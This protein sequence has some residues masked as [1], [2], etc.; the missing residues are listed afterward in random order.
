MKLRR[1]EV[2]LLAVCAL[3]PVLVLVAVWVFNGSIRKS[4]PI[5]ASS[6]AS[7]WK[8][9]VGSFSSA[10]EGERKAIKTIVAAM[11]DQLVK[12]PET[13]YA[14]DYHFVVNGTQLKGSVGYCPMVRQ[15]SCSLS[16]TPKH[17]T[18]RDV[19]PG[20]LRELAN[21]SESISGL[22]AR[23]YQKDES[24]RID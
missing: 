23:R 1:K 17:T 6:C 14:A 2:G 19:R 24:V 15:F 3:V 12:C 9:D 5:K 11:A 7:F 10:Q 21:N 20:T 8:T 16:D 18:W 4:A 22:D 13:S